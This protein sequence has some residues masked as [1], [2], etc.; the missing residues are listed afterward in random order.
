MDRQPGWLNKSEMAASLGISVQAFDKWKVGPV[1]RKGR[2]TFY[3]VRSVLDNRLAVVTRKTES[4]GDHPEGIDPLAEQKLIQERLRLTAA[5]AY[6]QEQKNQVNDKQ[7]TPAD[8]AIFALSKLAAQI[9]SI[10][11]TV[12]L[13]IRRRHPDLAA[14]HI[15]SLQREVAT[16]RNTAAELG[17]Q[18]PELL[19][20]YL[21]TLDG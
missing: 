18:L 5:Q 1:G 10:L 8:F 4:D 13:K 12:P 3:D 6:A 15:E 14:R 19:D 2:E 20:E 16:A 11:D 21:S 7:L 9:G 17:E